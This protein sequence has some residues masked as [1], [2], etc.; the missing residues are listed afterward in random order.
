MLAAI[1]E[2]PDIFM[3]DLFQPIISEIEALT[4]LQY[5]DHQTSMRIIADHLKAAVFLINE[6]V[7]P[8]NK[9][10]GYVLRRLI[11][12]SIVKL[13]QLSGTLKPNYLSIIA[14]QG[15]IST[16]QSRS[17]PPFPNFFDS[18]QKQREIFSALDNESQQ[19]IKT[20]DKGLKQLNQLSPFDLYQTYG[21][22]VEIT[23]ELYAQQGRELDL[24]QFNQELKHHQD[25]SRTAGKGMFQGGLQ[26]HS[27]ITTKYHTAT[28]LLH[29]A[30]R[31][32][33]GNHV[34]QTGSNI[35]H[36]RLRFDF[37]HDQPL[38]DQQL[39]QVEDLVNQQIKNN[40]TVTCQTM[41]LQQARSQNALAFFAEKYGDQVKVY[42][43]GNFSKEVCGGPHVANTADIGPITIYKQES[44]GSGRRRLYAKIV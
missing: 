23:Q 14:K 19:F 18:N 42:S 10:Q 8:S 41:S 38:S 21:F 20:L 34:R 33:L 32:V 6:G 16:Y 26:D 27:Q 2:Q 12:R 5:S 11:R 17:T 9:L 13:Y 36:Q 28:H 3:T 44:V 30:L 15:V 7:E 40:L 1:N 25:L 22:P 35:T 37:T 39:Q 43:I 29:Q 4:N 24:D 31:Q